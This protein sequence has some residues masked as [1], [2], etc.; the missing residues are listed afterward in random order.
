MGN[1][2]GRF[3]MGL[4]KRSWLRHPPIVSLIPE[5]A[6]ALDR[7]QTA[8]FRR[9]IAGLIRHGAWEQAWALIELATEVHRYN[10]GFLRACEK[11]RHRLFSERG[12]A[13][14]VLSQPFG[15]LPCDCQDALIQVD[16]RKIRYWGCVAF[17]GI[18]RGRFRGPRR[19]RFC[20]AVVAERYLIRGLALAAD[21]QVQILQRRFGQGLSWEDSGGRALFAEERG[22]RGD[23]S[24][25]WASYRERQLRSW[26]ELFERIQ[27]IGYLSQAE[28][29]A[30]GRPRG[31]HGLFNE[32]EVCV[33]GKGDVLF[34]EG[35]HR[36]VV[37]QILGL[38]SI[39]VI[40]NVWSER[41]VRK[42]PG[43]FTAQLAQE[44]LQR[45]W[46]KKRS[47]RRD[48]QS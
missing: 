22:R 48:D 34:L 6:E 8:F 2:V 23:R 31:R 26:D 21:P 37:A 19:R 24:I 13:P 47:R 5:G 36:L 4:V 41:F 30:K 12:G 29:Q 7:R 33:N 17:P 27:R 32:V 20:N 38:P 35:K 40:V 1:G 10:P 46:L 44:Q 25:T 18:S 15:Q 43:P 42:L 16:P 9:A 14:P 28:L 45:R 3:P 11:A 39:P